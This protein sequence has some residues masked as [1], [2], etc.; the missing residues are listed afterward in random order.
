MS[1]ETSLPLLTLGK[2]SRN[3]PT[4]LPLDVQSFPLLFLWI[5]W[6]EQSGLSVLKA[7]SAS[8]A[9]PFLLVSLFVLLLW[10]SI[11]FVI[12]DQKTPHFQKVK[13]SR[14]DISEDLE[15]WGEGLLNWDV[16]WRKQPQEEDMISSFWKWASTTHTIP[17]KSHLPFNLVQTFAVFLASFLP[18]LSG[19][20]LQNPLLF[21]YRASFSLLWCVST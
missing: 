13:V 7:S 10:N 12:T 8:W 17:R 18:F 4:L 16:Q 3:F 6:E 11:S 2:I 1:A 19:T 21:S 14:E 15:E 5:S 9:I 20:K